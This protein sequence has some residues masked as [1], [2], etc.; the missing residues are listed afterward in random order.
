M[1]ERRNRF[2]VEGGCWGHV[3][4]SAQFTSIIFTQTYV[5][6]RTHTFTHTH[7]D[8]VLITLSKAISIHSQ[9]QNP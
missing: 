6:A 5:R 1:H 2:E 9:N 8:L 7:N 3:V 4:E